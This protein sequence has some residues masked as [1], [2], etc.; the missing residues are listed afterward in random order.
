MTHITAVECMANTLS[1]LDEPVSDLQVMT[2]ITCTLP[3][4]YNHF[5]S[6]SDK[7]PQADKNITLFTSRL[8]KEECMTKMYNNR[9]PDPSDTAFFSSNFPQ[10]NRFSSTGFSR[11]RVRG[12]SRGRGGFNQRFQFNQ[13]RGGS[14]PKRREV[15]KKTR[16]YNSSLSEATKGRRKCTE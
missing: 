14:P 10:Q 2:K 3:S 1:D 12:G 6:A 13:T 7:V 4:S 9:E 11:R 5:I 16:S 15:E 8:L